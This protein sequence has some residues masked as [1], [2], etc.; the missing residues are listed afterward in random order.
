MN[1]DW[2]SFKT[3]VNI[4]DLNEKDLK[5]IGIATT[6]KKIRHLKFGKVTFQVRI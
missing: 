2:G 4:I 6:R 5:E 3:F 1:K